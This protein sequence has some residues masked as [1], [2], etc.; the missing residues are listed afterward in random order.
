MYSKLVLA[1]DLIFLSV[2]ILW[3]ECHWEN[4]VFIASFVLKSQYK[5]QTHG[6]ETTDE[7]LPHAHPLLLWR[8]SPSLGRLIFEDSSSLTLRHSHTR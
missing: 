4:L 6:K 7:G 5:H 3:F 1:Y 8:N 2:L